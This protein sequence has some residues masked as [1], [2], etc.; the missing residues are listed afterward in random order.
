MAVE[1]GFNYVR[2]FVYWKGTGNMAEL[3]FGPVVKRNLKHLP[4]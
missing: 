2:V 4:E 1:A 3:F